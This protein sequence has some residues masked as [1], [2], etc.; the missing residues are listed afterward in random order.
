MFNEG[1]APVSSIP[2][3]GQTLA[4]VTG[5]KRVMPASSLSRKKTLAPGRASGVERKGS[6][7]LAGQG[8]SAIGHDRI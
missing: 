3:M 8:V 6:S 5:G 7:G 4:G 1:E 2:S